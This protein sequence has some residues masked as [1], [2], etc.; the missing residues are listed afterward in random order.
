[1]TYHDRQTGEPVFSAVKKHSRPAEAWGQDWDVHWHDHALQQ[2]PWLK[3]GEKHKPE[4]VYGEGKPY[5]VYYDGRSIASNSLD[6]Y[7]EY[8]YRH[9][10]RNNFFRP[11]SSIKEAEYPTYPGV[12]PQLVTDE[13]LE[14]RYKNRHVWSRHDTGEPVFIVKPVKNINFATGYG[15]EVRAEWHPYQKE[16][17]PNIGRNE[18]HAGHPRTGEIYSS[19]DR[20]RHHNIEEHLHKRY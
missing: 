17:H 18:P 13:P 6:H 19:S 12:S 14:T 11:A 9:A 2:H 3:E 5:D 1:H 15:G 7:V 20:I 4:R 8:R 16:L 10:A